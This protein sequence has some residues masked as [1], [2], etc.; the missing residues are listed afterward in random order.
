MKKKPASRSAFFNPR[1][2]ISFAFCSIGVLLALLAFAL[3]PGATALAKGAQ[4]NQPGAQARPLS[5]SAAVTGLPSASEIAAMKDAAAKAR[6]SRTTVPVRSSAQIPALNRPT[7]RAPRPQP[8]VALVVLYDQTD[9]ASGAGTSSQNFETAIDAF[10]DQAADD[11]VVP[12]AQTWNIQQI[13]VL[14]AYFNGAGP[15]ASA[16]VIFYTDSATLPGTAVATYTSAAVVDDGLGNFNIALSPAAVLTA[17]TYWV[18]VQANMDFGVG[19]QWAWNDRTVQSNSGAAWQ[20]PGDGFGSGCTTWGRKSTCVPGAAPDNL[21]T[22]LG[23]TGGGSSPTPTPS[24]TPTTGPLWY[25][26]DFDGVN[27]LANEQDTSLGAGQFASVYDNFNV[28]GTGWTITEVFSDNLSS[29]NVTGANW[30]I[31]TGMSAGNGGTL[32]ASGTTVTPVVTPTGRSGFNFT[33]F[34]VKVTGLNVVL[35]PCR[36][37]NSTGSM[38]RRSA[39]SRAVPLDRPSLTGLASTA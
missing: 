28:T 4:Q 1:V 35:P 26:G 25:N 7:Q 23:T 14:G 8:N 5:P 12:A 37:A 34:Q 21:F 16:N 22:L 38:S 36:Q 31:R 27:G 19:G 33:E 15:A 30:E 29:T 3:Y 10:D 18:S 32:V 17:G 24:G 6:Q 39:T 13:N 20:N 11:F 2:L 9:N